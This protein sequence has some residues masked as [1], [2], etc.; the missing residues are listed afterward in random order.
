M[1]GDAAEHNDLADIHVGRYFDGVDAAKQSLKE[2]NEKNFTNFVV[3][4]NNKRSLV[5]YCKHSVHRDS[6]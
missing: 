3:E 5:F 4:T 6:K 1:E 2:F